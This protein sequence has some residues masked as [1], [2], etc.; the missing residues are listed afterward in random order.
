VT[1][2]GPGSR[3]GRRLR[4]RF[5]PVEV[6]L[7][8]TSTLLEFVDTGLRLLWNDDPAPVAPPPA[9]STSTKPPAA[10]SAPAADSVS[11]PDMPA[12]DPVG[13]APSVGS[14]FVGSAS[15]GGQLASL[16]RAGVNG[17][18]DHPARI[19]TPVP[20]RLTEPAPPCPEVAR[21]IRVS[22]VDGGV[23]LEV[24]TTVPG[25]G[26]VAAVLPSSQ[27]AELANLLDNSFAR[28]P[29]I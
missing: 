5:G 27:A 25:S 22:P 4:R 26:T 3:V 20:R 10:T 1:D 16:L 19:R 21:E 6:D 11:V 9:D 28:R 2:G 24:E 8:G 23:R 7:W 13:G 14:R 15:V 29:S 18:L 12:A 17:M